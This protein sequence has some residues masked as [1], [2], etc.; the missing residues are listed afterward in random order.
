MLFL[1]APSPAAGS[2]HLLGARNVRKGMLTLNAF[3]PT[4]EELILFLLRSSLS[5]LGN[6]LNASSGM[7]VIE[8]PR[9]CN[10]HSAL[11]VYASVCVCVCE[12]VDWHMCM[13][14]DRACMCVGGYQESFI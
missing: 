13:V 4:A 3:G 8:L 11:G 7:E 9:I 14:R 1:S 12:Q 5:K 2:S 10:M 6:P